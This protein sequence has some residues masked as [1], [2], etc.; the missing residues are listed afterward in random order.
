MLRSHL[1][2]GQKQTFQGPQVVP[3]ESRVEEKEA[4]S[5]AS[6]Q[7]P[8]LPTED[9]IAKGC[10]S[11]WHRSCTQ[12]KTNSAEVQGFKRLKDFVENQVDSYSFFSFSFFNLCLHSDSK[13]IS[14]IKLK[15]VF[16]DKPD[17]H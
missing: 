3:K 17:V 1:Q 14:P 4:F 9:Y 15:V 12:I 5:I 8:F 10:I 2:P 6:K 11:F 16:S 13:E 7:S